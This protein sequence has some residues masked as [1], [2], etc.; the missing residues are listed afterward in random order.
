[1][2]VYILGRV[3]THT[4][5]RWS[6]CWLLFFLCNETFTHWLNFQ[7][8]LHFHTLYLRTTIWISQN[9]PFVFFKI[10]FSFHLLW[11]DSS[12]LSPS[13]LHSISLTLSLSHTHTLIDHLKFIIVITSFRISLTSLSIYLNLCLFVWFFMIHFY[14]FRDVTASHFPLESLLIH[15]VFFE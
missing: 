6:Q 14:R 2:W 10:S 7:T 4:H 13:L 1:M 9:S 11:K 8:V 3:H 15:Y 5:T 12:L